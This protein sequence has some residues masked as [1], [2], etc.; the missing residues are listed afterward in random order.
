MVACQ[1]MIGGAMAP[2]RH[3]KGAWRDGDAHGMRGPRWAVVTATFALLLAACGGD[4]DTAEAAV[5]G[6]E[7][8]ATSDPDP[9]DAAG[10][11]AAAEEQEEAADPDAPS[12]ERIIDSSLTGEDGWGQPLDLDIPPAGIG[13]LEIEG[14]T[15]EF[16]VQCRGTGVISDDVMDGSLQL[17]Q[18]IPF[19]FSMGGPGQSEEFGNVRIEVGR[20]IHVAGDR[21]IQIRNMEWGG[22]GQLDIVSFSGV[23]QAVSRIQSPS[24]VDPD[25][26]RLPVVQV[27]EDG[28]VT[29]EGEMTREFETDTEALEGPFTFAGRCQETWPGD[30]P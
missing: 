27:S 18:Y 25:G 26:A 24:S 5:D 29:A 3:G 9:D 7:E 17:N 22:E 4:D 19:S 14:R 15:F 30:Q 21:A 2:R 11:E 12:V 16:D 20:S 23:G 10:D 8:V 28:V 1:T 13:V 6:D